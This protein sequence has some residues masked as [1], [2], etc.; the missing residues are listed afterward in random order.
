LGTFIGPKSA[1]WN[2]EVAAQVSKLLDEGFDPAQVWKQH[3][4]GRMPDKSLFSEIDDSVSS[5][6][7]QKENAYGFAGSVQK[8]TLPDVFNH[9]ELYDKYDL[10]NVNTRLESGN[11]E[12][13]TYT[14]GSSNIN[15]SITVGAPNFEMMKPTMLHEIQHA[16]QSKE[17]WAR[18]GNP[19]DINL[20]K[21]API[22][23]KEYNDIGN[24]LLPDTMTRYKAATSQ[25]EKDAILSERRMLM[26][27]QHKMQKQTPDDIQMEIYRRLTGEAQARE[28]Q[29]RMSLNMNER[30]NTYPLKGDKL[31]EVKLKDLINHYDTGIQSHVMKRNKK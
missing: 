28:T 8:G 14:R 31:G 25:A 13:G 17:G 1:G 3:L 21:F 29:N 6:V 2:S 10:S 23:Q 11:P 27:R 30:R 16:V 24:V 20:D 18:G 15:P 9:K 5:F 19:T 26:A 12:G 22:R 7:P 4:I